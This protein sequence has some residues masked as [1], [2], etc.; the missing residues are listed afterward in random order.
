MALSIGLDVGMVERYL[1]E[2]EEL[3]AEAEGGGSAGDL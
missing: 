2:N 3:R 1:E